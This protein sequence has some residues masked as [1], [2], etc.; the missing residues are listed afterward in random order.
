MFFDLLQNIC[1]ESES[2]S[3]SESE[4]K[5]EKKSPFIENCTTRFSRWKKSDTKYF[6][7]MSKILVHNNLRQLHRSK[8]NHRNIIVIGQ[9][10]GFGKID[11]FM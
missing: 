2:E 10:I 3:V 9:I 4:S 11:S 8:K 6:F 1:I 7:G 5:R